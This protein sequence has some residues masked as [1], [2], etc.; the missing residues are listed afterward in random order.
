MQS[1]LKKLAQCFLKENGMDPAD[2]DIDRGCQTFVA[3]MTN[4]LAGAASSLKMIPTYVSTG[5]EIPVGEPVIAIDAGGTNFRV[6]V[7]RFDADRQ[8]I[9]ED[10]KLYPM[11]GTHG[12]ISRDEFFHTVA[13]YLE[14]LLDKAERIGFCFSYPTQI[15]PNGD[16]RLIRFC[17]EVQVDDVEGEL[18]GSRLLEAI[19]AAGQKANKTIILLNDTVTTLLA[20]KAARANRKYGSY[21][22]FILGTGTNTCYIESNSAIKKLPELDSSG[23]M[24]INIESGAYAKAAQGIIDEEYDGGT[25]NPGEHIFEKM[26]SG[27]YFGDL[28]LAVLKKAAAAGLLTGACAQ[29]I[30]G[31]AELGTKDV[32]AFIDDPHGSG[33]L[34]RCCGADD[35]EGERNRVVIYYLIDL[36]YERAAKYVAIN[37]CAVVQ[38]SGQGS[39]PARPVCITADGTMFHKSR[40]FRQKLDYY[41]KEYLEDTLGLYCE[42]IGVDNATLLGAAIAG[43]TVGA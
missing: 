16:G 24:I 28:A 9:I 27:G 1:E 22:G 19:A 17:K 5:K 7:A 6:C 30:P 41:I 31:V 37:L 32:N 14:P 25:T 10:Y 35:G 38:K 40:L 15:L 29:N 11:P 39:D 13:G 21:I 42:F 34:A 3:E 23:N 20:G 26:I 18:I 12:R 33:I 8:P 4:G 36:L 2:I 43:L